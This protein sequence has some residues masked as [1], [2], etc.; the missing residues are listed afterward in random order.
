MTRIYQYM[1]PERVVI[2]MGD[3]GIE[4]DLYTWTAPGYVDEVGHLAECLELGLPLLTERFGESSAE[5]D[6]IR[7]LLHAINTSE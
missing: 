5:A 1:K 7:K 2:T 4:V 3:D 6:T